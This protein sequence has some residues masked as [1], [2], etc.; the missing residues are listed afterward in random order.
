MKVPNTLHV[1]PGDDDDRNVRASG[2]AADGVLRLQVTLTRS[3]D[4]A[5]FDSLAALDGWKRG[6]RVR[7]LLSVG[8]IVQNMGAAS[9][10]VANEPRGTK[11]RRTASKPHHNKPADDVTVDVPAQCEDG[12]PAEHGQLS[13]DTDAFIGASQF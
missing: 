10:L 11:P 1:Q 5:M 2:L 6:E 12:T 4:P 8:H 3:T 9:R 7:A 13:F